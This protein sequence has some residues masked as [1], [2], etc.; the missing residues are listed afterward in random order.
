MTDSG[1]DTFTYLWHVTSSN[2]QTVADGTNTTFNFQALDNGVYTVNITV[3][4]DDGA[5]STDQAIV[6]VNNVTPVVNLGTDISA[7]EGSVVS[8]PGIYTDPG[9]LDTFTYLWHITASN[10]Q[11]IADLTTK[12]ASF[13]PVDNGTYTLSLTVRD[14]DGAV[15]SD[16]LVL[17]VN[18]VA[19]Q[20]L[21]A[22]S[23]FL[24]NEGAPVSFLGT[25]TD[26]G[27]LDTFTLTWS[28]VA[29]NGQVV[30]GG[31]GSAFSF[32]A[33]DNGNYTVT[34]TV[35]DKDGGTSSTQVL[36]IA[37]NIA[38]SANAGADQTVKEGDTVNLA[39]TFT[40]PGTRDTFTFL[41]HVTAS[42][43]QVIA[44]STAQNFSF[45][46]ADNG[47][48]TVAFTVRDNAG[49]ANTDTAIV[50]V[51]NVAPTAN[52]GVD[53]T[54]N[55]AT[56]VNLSG[57]FSDVGTS[58][59]FTLRWHVTSTN[60]QVI[61]DGTAANFS[62]VPTDNGTHTATFTVRD[63]DGAT[64][65]DEVII[66]V[67]NVAPTLAVGIGSTVEVGQ[68][69]KISGIYGETGADQLQGIVDFGDGTTQALTLRPDKTFDV[70][71]VFSRTGT[72][73]VKVT[74]SDDDGGNISRNV[75]YTVKAAT[76]LPLPLLAPLNNGL[77][78]RS[79]VTSLVLNFNV[80]VGATL[81]SSDIILRNL[82]T[83]A[84]ITPDKFTLTYN[85]TTLRA[86]VTF[87]NLPNSSLPNGVYR[88]RIDSTSVLGNNKALAQ[89]FVADFHVLAGDANGDRATNDLDLFRIWQNLLKTPDNRD[90]NDDLN[91]DGQVT[92]ADLDVVRANYGAHLPAI[93]ASGSTSAIT[94]LNTS[95]DPVASYYSPALK[96]PSAWQGSF[97][98]DIDDSTPA[99]SYATA[100]TYIAPLAEVGSQ[101]QSVMVR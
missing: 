19:P 76:P 70:T 28:V 46:P 33:A 59:T 14:D 101:T 51:S 35:R 37:N 75:V 39:G 96:A 7:N 3:T 97:S 93:G 20:N 89:D 64:T 56:P 40:D 36:V 54:V 9:A 69:A 4:D 87:T 2:G 63:D 82:T 25:F 74:I 77:V 79:K 81:T 42:N 16:S 30:P 67:N 29:S 95:Q 44:D 84:I 86:V 52:G 31:T 98:T 41:W 18:N 22:G 15:S 21:K 68:S 72:F 23:N 45:K 55:E 26:P 11:V 49:A 80:D 58:D 60:G 5:I 92:L 48:Y 17:T 8:I 71:H 94:S 13:V 10:G 65:T 88:L 73:T 66:T 27:S 83:G 100:S 90:L 50:T 62:F 91:G 47:T 43:G 24:T 78:E 57:T 1:T 6:T 34:F 32:V 12:D 99:A 61:A 85:P 53:Q 38:P